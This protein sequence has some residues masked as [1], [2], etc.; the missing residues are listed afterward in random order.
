MGLFSNKP[1][2]KEGAPASTRTKWTSA[3][4]G[5]HEKWAAKRSAAA[6]KAKEAILKKNAARK[7]KKT[8]RKERRSL[9]KEYRVKGRTAAKKI[10]AES[11]PGKE[12]RVKL[13]ASKAFHKVDKE[14]KVGGFAAF[15]KYAA[16]VTTQHRKRED[17]KKVRVDRKAERAARRADRKA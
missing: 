15:G 17:R 13:G 12:R 7:E 11:E 8:A 16:K 4:D 2:D 1:T 9:K 5:L 10:R 6:K 14:G 3:D